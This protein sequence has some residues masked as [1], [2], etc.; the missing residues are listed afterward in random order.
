MATPP[1]PLRGRA[2]SVLQRGGSL[3]GWVGWFEMSSGAR[4]ILS[5]R[6][7]SR[8]TSWSQVFLS[9]GEPIAVEAGDEVSLDVRYDPP[10]WSWALAAA[11]TRRSFSELE[12]VPLP[13]EVHREEAVPI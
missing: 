9:A 12:A 7:P 8:V 6:P 11:G 4:P 1:V 5:T 13:R 10:F 3:C 2:S